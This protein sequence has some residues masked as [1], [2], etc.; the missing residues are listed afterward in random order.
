M[1]R[2]A[3]WRGL[4]PAQRNAFIASFLGWTL[5]AFDYFLVV[6]VLR[7]VA[8]DLHS[9]VLIATLAVTLTLVM[10]PVGALIFG[11]LAD[12]YGRRVPLMVDVGFYSLIELLTAISPNITT[13]IILRAIYGIAMGGEWGLGAALAMESLPPQKR[14]LYSGILQE[15]YAVG[16][17]LAGAVFGLLF[18]H[19]GWRWMF[20]IGA[21]PALL[22]LYIRSH[23]PESPAWTQ[24]R[25]QRSHLTR[26]QL[27]TV[28]TKYWPLFLFSIFF[29]AAFNA[30]SHGTQDPYL[31][32]FLEGYH[33]FTPAL[34]GAINSIAAVGAICGGIMFGALS[35]RFGRR[36]TIVVSAAFGLVVVPMWS[37]LH[38]VALLA[39]GG[40]FMQFAVQGAWGIIPA[41]LNE[42]S[43]GEVRAT[44]PGFTYQLGNLIAAPTLT[45]EAWLATK[46][47]SATGGHPNYPMALAV[48]VAAA[49]LLV[50]MMTALGNFIAPERMDEP[51]A[52]EGTAEA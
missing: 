7:H 46:R 36:N 52:G 5:D 15:G 34:A 47:F 27:K 28:M 43:P 38:N 4:T 16:N 49:L 31:S 1:S 11:W 17:L 29:M 3:Q 12:R 8:K 26:A 19:I 42:I 9:T 20:V 10:R 48:F 40:F 44:F 51:F 30:M 39:A 21:L 25:A 37:L 33:H 6:V 13:F 50:I 32:L 35:Q 23:V 18:T 22:I 14:G 41:H 24:M 45:V 2:A